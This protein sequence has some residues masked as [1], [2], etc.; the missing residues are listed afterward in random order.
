MN[1]SKIHGVIFYWLSLIGNLQNMWPFA[2]RFIIVS[3]LSSNDNILWKSVLK[4]SV[5]KNISSFLWK[6]AIKSIF[7]SEKWPALKGCSVQSNRPKHAQNYIRIF[8]SN[9][10]FR[11]FATDEASMTPWKSGLILSTLKMYLFVQSVKLSMAE[12]EFLDDS[13]QLQWC[14]GELINIS[15]FE[16]LFKDGLP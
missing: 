4:F 10:V 16:S 13:T 7:L 8:H 6:I 12:G 15:S 14:F 9:P 11:N 3:Q 5:S 1:N 2:V